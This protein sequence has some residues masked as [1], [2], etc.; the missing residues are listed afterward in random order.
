MHT[1]SQGNVVTVIA[2]VAALPEASLPPPPLPPPPALA[3]EFSNILRASTSSL[4][5]VFGSWS[6]SRRARAAF[7]RSVTFEDRSPSRRE[8]REE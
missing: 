6:F 7:W 4:L 8:A 1:R 3:S 2:L 5:S